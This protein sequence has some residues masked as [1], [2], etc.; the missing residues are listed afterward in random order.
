VRCHVS[1]CFVRPTRIAGL[2]VFPQHRIEV[3][4]V[5]YPA[6]TFSYSVFSYWFVLRNQFAI[7]LQQ[8]LISGEGA[9]AFL[10]V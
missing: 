7:V 10:L 9:F 1:T 4:K 5:S 8:F 2:V 3:I 6:L